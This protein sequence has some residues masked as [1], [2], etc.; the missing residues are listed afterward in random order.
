MSDQSTLVTEQ[1]FRYVAEHTARE[2]AF[3]TQLK[4]AA[5]A[6]GIPSI[7]IAPEQASC[8]QILLRLRNARDVIEVGTLAGYSAIAM[9]RALPPGGR[10]HT[11]ELEPKHAQFAEDWI[12]RSD[13]ADRIT[14]HRGAGMEVLP[15]FEAGSADAVFLDADKSSYP[16]YLDE[17]LR[18][19]RPQGLVMV[20]NAFA[21]GELFT[22]SPRDREVGAVRAFNEKMREERRVQSVIVPLGDG[23]WVGV[24]R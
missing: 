9:A 22:D 10:V 4:N 24:V 1:H 19:L 7:W 13:V 16:A 3:L 8:M 6:A 18:I 17:S 23:L 15:R 21:F 20:D 11:I 5:R 12:A 14:L 2:D